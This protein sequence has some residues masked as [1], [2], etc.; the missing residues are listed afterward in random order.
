MQSEMRG[1]ACVDLFSH[2][3]GY[4]LRAEFAYD[5]IVLSQN[6]YDLDA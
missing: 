3:T 4:G 5:G 6:R 2:F 1:P